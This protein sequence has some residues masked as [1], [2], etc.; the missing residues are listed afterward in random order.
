MNP[1]KAM[2]SGGYGNYLAHLGE[3]GRCIR[4]LESLQKTWQRS[5]LWRQMQ[6]DD[7]F[8]IPQFTRSNPD[9]LFRLQIFH[10][11]QFVRQ[12]ATELPV[13]PQNIRKRR[14]K[15]GII[16]ALVDGLLNLDM[17][18]RLKLQGAPSRFSGIVFAQRLVDVARMRVVALNQ[19]RVVAVHRA[20][21][22]SDGRCDD[23][24]CLPCQRTG[25]R[26]QIERG[27]FKPFLPFFGRQL[28]F[29]P[30]RVGK[31]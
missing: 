13:Q 15:S 12:A 31:G 5:N 3:M 22:R 20:N 27:I 4:L 6:A 11:E 30:A 19:I 16:A 18:N 29:L 1:D 9:A 26:D 28:R 23:R 8:T 21:Q 24:I 7:Y 17:R 25:A 14:R 2:M 10:P